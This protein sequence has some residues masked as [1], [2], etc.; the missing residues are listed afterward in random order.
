[1]RN[2]IIFGGNGFLGRSLSELLVRKKYNV[3]V[4][5]LDI[6]N[7]IEGV[8]YIK[9]TILNKKKV[10]SSIKNKDFIFHFAGI[11]DIEEC[12]EDPLKAVKYNIEATSIILNASAINNVKK[13]IFAST[14]Y[15]HSEQG[16][17]Y[18]TTKKAAELL[19]ENY[20]KLHGLQ[21]VI[22]R[23]GSLYGPNA[24]HFNFFSNIITQGI[25]TNKMIRKGSG[26]EV[27]RY[28]H[29][30]DCAKCCLE[31]L[32]NKYN[33][34]FYDITGKEVLTIRK[35]LNKIKK[36]LSGD[37]EI[38]FDD[39]DL[40]EHHYIKTPFT[41]KEKRSKKFDLINPI[42]LDRGIEQVISSIKKKS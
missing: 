13:I 27:R 40:Y 3:T 28:I 5:D 36:K 20:Y 19:I 8:K 6:K 23:F 39:Q 22:L 34:E 15:V 25:K 17:I 7:K 30:E 10:N 2:I 18:R 37:L 26:N 21:F 9:D 32:K 11:A 33:N 42:S 31:V 12:N 24:N 1:M 41:Y 4:Y 16:G 14:I 29:V 35:L 38:I